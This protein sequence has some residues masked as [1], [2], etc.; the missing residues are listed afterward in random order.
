MARRWGLPRQWGTG[1][2]TT[3]PTVRRPGRPTGWA[4][5][6]ISTTQMVRPPDRPT[7]WVAQPTITMR[8]VRLREEPPRWATRPTTTT[9]TVRRRDGPRRWA[10]RPTTTARMARRQ[11]RPLEQAG[12]AALSV[13]PSGGGTVSVAQERDPPVWRAA[14]FAAVA[15]SC[16]PPATVAVTR[17]KTSIHT[18]FVLLNCPVRDNQRR[19]T[20]VSGLIIPF[21]II[22]A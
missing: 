19:T 13:A 10:T 21:G 3:T 5:R 7:G 14:I 18:L 22:R 17:T 1:R 11:E 20:L 12:N 4:T 16:A 9:R 6:P 8:T 15:T 2:T